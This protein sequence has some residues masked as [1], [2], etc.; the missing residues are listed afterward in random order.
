[1]LQ[2]ISPWLARAAALLLVLGCSLSHAVTAPVG[3]EST[4]A[5]IV[6]GTDA[7]A[8]TYP[9]MTALIQKTANTTLANSLRQFCGASLIAPRWVLTAAHC[10]EGRQPEDFQVLIGRDNIDGSG[11]EL[12]EVSE[13]IVNPRYNAVKVT[14][15]VALL[16]L[17]AP[18]TAVPVALPAAATVGSFDA[19]SGTALG[20]GS[21]TGI[22]SPACT[23]VFPQTTPA[24]PTDFRC[25]SLV[26]GKQGPIARL[27]SGQ[28]AILDN[29]ACYRRYVAFLDQHNY[30][31]PPDLRADQPV[32]SGDL[33]TID[34]ALKTSVCYGD[35]GGPLLAQVAGQTVVVG[36]ASFLIEKNCQG[37]NNLQFFTEVTRF[38]DF[39]Q[40]AMASNRDLNFSQWC[41]Q[42]PL[43]GVTVLP[44]PDGRASASVAWPAVASAVGYDLVYVPLPRQD[45]GVGRVQLAAAATA[46][47]LTLPVGARYLVAV[48]A[49]G[50]DCDSALSATVEVSVP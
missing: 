18:A 36:I 28:L 22:R 24:K 7:P 47:T 12:I 11:G 8:G 2:K 38:L 41:P 30:A 20:W 48:Q 32:Q 50:A 4:T 29:A 45:S 14:N 9:W 15:D 44:L 13:I 40:Q 23:L 1:M 16:R 35:S 39:I 10:L 37:T 21:S 6:N 46:L 34:A 27:Q 25:N 42:A 31:Y 17:A 49:K 3:S 5:A 19:M 33:C 26:L 43:P